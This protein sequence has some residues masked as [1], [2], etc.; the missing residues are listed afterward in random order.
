V[1][2][3]LRE[4]VRGAESAVEEAQALR[5]PAEEVDEARVERSER[6]PF[7][8]FHHERRRLRRCRDLDDAQLERREPIHLAQQLAVVVPDRAAL[9][10]PGRDA[11]LDAVVAGELVLLLAL[12]GCA[13]LAH[14]L[15]LRQAALRADLREPVVHRHSFSRCSASPLSS[16]DQP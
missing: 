10:L 15:R 5:L 7:G 6:Q 2:R 16:T 9:V 11:A 13:D 4:Q 8:Q 1:G 12:R 14:E 3:R